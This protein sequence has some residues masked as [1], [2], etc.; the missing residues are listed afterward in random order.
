MHRLATDELWFFHM[1]DPLDMLMLHPDGRSERLTLG[2]DLAAGQKVQH[3]VPTATWQGSTSRPTAGGV[4]YS[5]VSCV[6]VPGFAW[7]DFE[8]G[9]REALQARYP[10]AVADIERLT[11]VTPAKG[12]L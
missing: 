7:Q 11:R 8:L 10:D 4:G 12:H 9:E 3:L 6:M 5:L 2:H 1:G